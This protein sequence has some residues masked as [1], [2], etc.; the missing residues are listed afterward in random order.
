MFVLVYV[1]ATAQQDTI[2]QK[3]KFFLAYDFGEAMVNS[4]QSLS[5]E[6]GLSFANKHLIRLVHMN[7]WLT[8]KHL[9]SDFV[10][11]VEGDH[12]EGRMVGLEGFYSIPLLKWRAENEAIYAS[13]SIGFYANEYQHLELDEGFQQ[14]SA[15]VGLELSYR[16]INPFG[17]KGL[18]YALTFPMRFHFNPH[19]E[20]TLGETTILSNKFDGN[21]WFFVGYQF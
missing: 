16:E 10:A 17:V 4:F 6:V 7:V 11:V 8:E 18:Y 3:P 13:P 5:G 2:S 20:V 15:T 9:S 12:V 1:G 19:E 21:I 14:K